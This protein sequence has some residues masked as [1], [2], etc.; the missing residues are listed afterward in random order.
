MPRAFSRAR[1]IMLRIDW[2]F[3]RSNVRKRR[4]ALRS[5]AGCAGVERIAAGEDMQRDLDRRRAVVGGGAGGVELE[6]ETDV[7]QAGHVFGAFEVAAHPEQVFGDAAQHV[8]LPPSG[9]R[10][11]APVHPAPAR[12]VEHPGVLGAAPLRAVDD[13][14]PL[15][16]RDAREPAGHHHDLFA[17]EHERA[18]VDVAAV[19]PAVDEGR[20]PAQ[21]D[22]RLGDVAARVGL[23][24]AGELVALLRGSRPGRSAS[25]SRRRRRPP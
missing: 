1:A 13:Q 24:L 3:V 7:E 4:T 19:E 17:V 25:R 23:D 16:Q 14:A 12:L 8:G 9:R 2:G 21:A 11:A 20:V 18:Q 6:V 10:R 5:G 22:R 15:R